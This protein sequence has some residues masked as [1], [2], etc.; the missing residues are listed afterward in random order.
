MTAIINYGVGN[1]FSLTGSLKHLGIDT[2]VTAD[3]DEI[4]KADR[5][6]LPGVGAF[7][8]AMNMLNNSGL[9]PLIHEQTKIKPFLGICL[10]MQLLFYIIFLSLSLTSIKNSSVFTFFLF[11]KVESKKRS[12]VITPSSIVCV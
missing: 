10:G 8:A 7:P 12:P 5:I 4:R 6:I 3:A 1:L 9:V 2:I 11:S